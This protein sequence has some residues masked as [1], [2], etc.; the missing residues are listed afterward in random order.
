MR[1][2]G[3]LTVILLWYKEELTQARHLGNQYTKYFHW[4]T[5]VKLK[6]LSILKKLLHI[7][8]HSSQ[9]IKYELGEN[10]NRE[11]ENTI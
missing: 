9:Q 6:V 1:T 10:H 7:L 8:K 2:S 3:L 11:H 5:Y 4:L